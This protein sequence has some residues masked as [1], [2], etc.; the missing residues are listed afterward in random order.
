MAEGDGEGVREDVTE[1]VG[2]GV[3]VGAAPV[4]PGPGVDCGRQ[5][6]LLSVS[7]SAGK[8]SIE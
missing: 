4:L 5:S 2:D 3:E 8:R 7:L 6:D 1:A